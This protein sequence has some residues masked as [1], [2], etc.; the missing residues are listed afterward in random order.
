MNGRKADDRPP[1]AGHSFGMAHS[2]TSAQRVRRTIDPS[3]VAVVALVAGIAA[4]AVLFVAAVLFVHGDVESSPSGTEGTIGGLRY[5]VA[6]AWLLDPHRSVDAALA[7]GLPATATRARGHRLYAVFVG[8][9]NETRRSL[10]AA[11]DI[12]LLDTQGREYAPVPLGS[13]NAFAYRPH[14]IGPHARVPA[15]SSPAGRD[16][17]AQGSML[18][19][20]ISQRSYD[21]GPLELVVHDPA[22]PMSVSHLQVA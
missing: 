9:T 14:V 21:A 4:V 10:P 13:S 11:T 3:A 16:L 12:T 18:V 2:R 20:R 22:H 15:P 19:F 5:D 7:K 8:V 17:S 1:R 6:N